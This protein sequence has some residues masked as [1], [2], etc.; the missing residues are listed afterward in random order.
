[1]APGNV[2]QQT[3]R[4]LSILRNQGKNLGKVGIVVDRGQAL[5]ARIA[6]MSFDS[7]GH[8]PSDIG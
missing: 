6:M 3:D 2:H 8:P 5:A 7:H 4:D 1:L